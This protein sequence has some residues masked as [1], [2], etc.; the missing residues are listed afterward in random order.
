MVLSCDVAPTGLHIKTW[1]VD[2]AVSE[3][4]LVGVRSRC[5]GEDL[6]S[7]TDSQDRNVRLKQLSDR[8]DGLRALFRIPGSIANDDSPR[9]ELENLINGIIVRDSNDACSGRQQT[10]YYPIFY[11]AVQDDYRRVRVVDIVNRL[12]RANVSDELPVV[13]VGERA[14]LCFDLLLADF[15]VGC[16]QESKHRSVGSDLASHCTSVYSFDSGHFL[17]FHPILELPVARPMT[18][19]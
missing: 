19:S 5:Q 7:K 4:Q 3:L 11:A 6:H 13:R 15:V 1:M 2:C 14:E 9:F 10:S 17:L 8:V 18:R 16:L 12:R